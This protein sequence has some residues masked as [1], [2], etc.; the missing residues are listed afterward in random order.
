VRSGAVSRCDRTASAQLHRF[1]PR[2]GH[3]TGRVD[4]VEPAPERKV[5]R[6][7]P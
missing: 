7:F 1:P 3:H 6:P 2:T 5:I 4:S